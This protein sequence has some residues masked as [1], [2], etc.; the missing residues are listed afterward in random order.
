MRFA[1]FVEWV[2]LSVI[3]T[4]MLFILCAFLV[5][6][7]LVQPVELQREQMEPTL[8]MYRAFGLGGNHD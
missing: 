6:F 3:M 2:F 5:D 7:M 1:D 8:E 4:C